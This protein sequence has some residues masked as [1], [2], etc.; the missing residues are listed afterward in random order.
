MSQI[1]T[2]PLKPTKSFY[3]R[4][5]ALLLLCVFLALLAGRFT[6]GRVGSGLP[7]FDLRL[8]FL[9]LLLTGIAVWIA[10]G[11][12]Y[13]PKPL[14]VTGAGFFIAWAFWLL[15]SSVWAPDGARVGDAFLDIV[16]LIAFTLV[17]W[18]L[19]SRLSA[20]STAR[21]WKWMLV[22]AVIYFALAMA[23]GPGAQGRYAA[24]GGGPNVFVRVMVLGAIAAL[25]FTSTRKKAIYLLPVPLFAV[26]AALSGSRGGLLSAAVIL[27]VF[28]IPICRQLGAKRVTGLLV[29]GVIGVWIF[30]STNPKI[31]AFV[32]DRFLEQTL[33]EGYSSGRDTIAEDALRLF[34]Q[35][36]ITGVGLDGYYVL[37]VSPETFEYPHNLVIAT[38]AETGIVGLVF[39]LGALVTVF[40]VV[41]RH[42]PIPATVL[43][44]AGAG[45]YQFVA[46]LFSGDYYD[47]RMMWF[48]LGLAAVEA[49]RRKTGVTASG[50]GTVSQPRRL[51]IAASGANLYRSY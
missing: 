23:A 37:Q 22:A 48:F 6:L 33:V 16:L 19:M 28:S 51:G 50:E 41:V 45:F 15:F 27:L 10:G 44:A 35:S 43:Y 12:G 20:E 18:G 34:G 29:I 46:G 9:Y 3:E 1:L 17:A 39:L 11:H 5:G 14:K 25:Y 40:A 42:R 26:G 7:D 49:G 47:T 21:I 4:V 32:Q 36:P 13:F 24:P 30:A 8:G 31:V 38:M 2:K